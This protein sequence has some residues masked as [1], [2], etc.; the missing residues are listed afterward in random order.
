MRKK[1]QLF[2]RNKTWRKQ[3]NEPE[4]AENIYV[5]FGKIITKLAETNEKKCLKKNRNVSK[6]CKKW[7]GK[8]KEK[9]L[10]AES[11]KNC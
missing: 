1:M 8:I 10:I 11:E 6:P 2:L 9:V 4:T 3:N 7:Q 5:W